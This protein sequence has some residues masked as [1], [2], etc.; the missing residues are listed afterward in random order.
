MEIW[1]GYTPKLYNG[2]FV[3]LNKRNFD[4]KFGRANMLGNQHFRYATNKVTL[5]WRKSKAH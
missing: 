2:H 3:E 1:G 5:G 4:A